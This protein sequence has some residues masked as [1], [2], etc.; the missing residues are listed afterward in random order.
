MR[1][2]TPSPTRHR[3]P[4]RTRTR[5]KSP[6]GRRSKSRTPEGKRREIFFIND[7]DDHNIE[8]EYLRQA[9]EGDLLVYASQAQW[10]S[11]RKICRK[12]NGIKKWVYLGE[13]GFGRKKRKKTKKMRK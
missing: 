6:P 2:R 9:N 1:S 10:G 3:R 13:I 8:A 4:S 5:S 12:E 7:Y 11:W